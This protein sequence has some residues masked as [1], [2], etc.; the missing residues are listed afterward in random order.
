[1]QAETSITTI[2]AVTKNKNAKLLDLRIILTFC[3]PLASII[4]ARN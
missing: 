3:K 2:E 1:V 4:A